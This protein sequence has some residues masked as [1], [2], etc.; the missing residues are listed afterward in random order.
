MASHSA[1][2]ARRTRNVNQTVVKCRAVRHKWRDFLHKEGS[3]SNRSRVGQS[4]KDF[5]N[6]LA[7]ALILHAIRGSGLSSVGGALKRGLCVQ[8]SRG[9]SV[10]IVS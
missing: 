4:E 10:F 2:P 8:R 5:P 1:E 6:A 7:L 9:S 3:L